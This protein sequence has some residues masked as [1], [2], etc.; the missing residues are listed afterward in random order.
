M[1][2]DPK[3][4]EILVCPK[5]HGK[6]VESKTPEGGEGLKCDACKL[7]YRV[8]DDIPEMLIDEA[9]KL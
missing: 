6:I 7:V 4:M 3:L 5:C 1:P 2:V 8:K 9:I